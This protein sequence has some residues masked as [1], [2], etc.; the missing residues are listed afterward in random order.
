MIF[1]SLFGGRITVCQKPHSPD[2]CFTADQLRA[3][4]EAGD[5]EKLAEARRMSV[6]CVLCQRVWLAFW[7]ES[8]Q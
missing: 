3:W 8:R 5:K 6:A 1:C 4:F 2:K 7:A